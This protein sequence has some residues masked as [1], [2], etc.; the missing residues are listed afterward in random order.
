M[1]TMDATALS[2]ERVEVS[3]RS[4]NRTVGSGVSLPNLSPASTICW[5]TAWIAA[6]LLVGRSAG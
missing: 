3:A 4:S 5:Y 1:T 2:A 6:R